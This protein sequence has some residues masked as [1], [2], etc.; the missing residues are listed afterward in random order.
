MMCVVDDRP[1]KVEA[2]ALSAGDKFDVNVTKNLTLLTIRHCTDELIH[3][4]TKGHRV[5]LRQQ[6]PETVQLLLS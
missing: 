2:F 3:E 1:E 5:V 4:L 6:T